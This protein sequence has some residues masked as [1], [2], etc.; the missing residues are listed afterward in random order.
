VEDPITE[1]RLRQAFADRALITARA[2]AALI[3][4]DEK[5]LAAMVR[6]GQ[7]AAITVSQVRR[8]SEADLRA[9]LASGGDPPAPLRRGQRFSEI[10]ALAVPEK[11]RPTPAR[12]PRRRPVG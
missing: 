5:T 1:A 7:I 8:F 11:A 12:A 4:V 10:S 9:F 2:A 3:G 6:R